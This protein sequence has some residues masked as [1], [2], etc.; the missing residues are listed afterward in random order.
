MEQ[1]SPVPYLATF[2]NCA[3]WVLYGLPV[4]HPHSI[5]VIT[6]N[7]AGFF[8]E[9]VYLVLFVLHSDKNRKIKVLLFM[10][11]EVFLVSILAIL[12][13]TLAHSTKLRSAIVGSICMVGNVMMY[14]SP[15][16]VM[17]LVITTKSVE[18]MPFFPSLF[19]FLN[20]ASWTAYALIRF[21]PFIAASNG[22]GAVLGLTQLLLYATFYK[23][24]K[25]QLA[26]RK[27]KA[28]E[29]GLT[30]K[31]KSSSDAPAAGIGLV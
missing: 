15:L 17:K 29:V 23:S 28:A 9:L 2:V 5:L 25:K 13:L 6:I 19:S 10:L 4:V 12:V 22:A 30:E 31:H 21:D 8:I 1:Y 27:G 24:T 16:A 20:G 26:E 14:A 3:L 18:Y 11:A 7:G